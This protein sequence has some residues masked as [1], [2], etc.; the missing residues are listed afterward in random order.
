VFRAAF[1]GGLEIT[2]RH[3]HSF[4]IG[5]YEELGEP[6]GLDAAIFT[7]VQDMRF[8]NDTQSWLLME[9]NVDLE[10][11]R[12]TITLYGSPTGRSVALDHRVIER[13]PKPSEPVYVD[14]PE[15]P[16]GTVKR[17]DIA[18]D[19]IKVEVYRVVR[20]A[21]RVIANDTFATTFKPWP[22]IYVRGTQ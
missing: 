15:L 18:R 19:G 2:E 9:S 17:T 22:D 16:A 12:L 11:Q 6:P 14:D 10:R 5:W 3:E 8:V 1:W 7:G 21:E 13:M 4:R 20:E